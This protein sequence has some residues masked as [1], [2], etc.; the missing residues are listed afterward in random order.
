MPPAEKR[1]T[2]KI[3]KPPVLA[4]DYGHV[5]AKC[6]LLTESK[7]PPQF[8]EIPLGFSTT[9][10]QLTVFENFLQVF[11]KVGKLS[12]TSFVEGKSLKI[13]VV[14]SG[15]L[16]S[17]QFKKILAHPPIDPIEALKGLKLRLIDVRDSYT[18]VCGFSHREK[19]AAEDV[20][21]WLPFEADPSEIENY[22]ENKILY[23]QLVPATLRDLYIEQALARE[24]ISQ[25]SDLRKER[26]AKELQ[27]SEVVLTGAVFAKA[28][29]F[30]QS[31]AIVLDSLE[32]REPVKILL[33]E[34]QWLPAVGTLA[35]YSLDLAKE[36]LSRCAMKSLGTLLPVPTPAKIM[37]DAGLGEAQEVIVEDEELILF[38]LDEKSEAQVVVEQKNEKKSFKVS[39]GEVGLVIDS[40]ER[41]LGLPRDN[42][43]RRRML[44]EWNRAI[45]AFGGT[46]EI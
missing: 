45:N 3:R 43:E 16:A 18:F 33:D 5:S 34:N 46:M 28:P 36:I 31:V 17:L 25:A 11:R 32:P 4:I 21:K 26:F 37:I 24:K 27:V 8:Y 38:P 12:G 15:E 20:L 40:R 39:G 13:P 1:T 6:L 29:R 19:V 10:P 42:T 23:N 35:F 9:H 7:K 30:E 14:V 2:K 22:L 44:K 41:P